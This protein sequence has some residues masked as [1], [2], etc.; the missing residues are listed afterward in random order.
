MFLGVHVPFKHMLRSL[1]PQ[2]LAFYN[3]EGKIVYYLFYFIYAW[4]TVYL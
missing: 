1:F 3:T 2:Y 4:L